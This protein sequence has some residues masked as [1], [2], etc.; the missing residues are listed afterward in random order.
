MIS[1]YSVGIALQISLKRSM[2]MSSSRKI[3]LYR[4][5]N[6]PQM[7][8]KVATSSANTTQTRTNRR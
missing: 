5:V 6:V 8:H 3:T 2:P 1:I 4:P 7:L